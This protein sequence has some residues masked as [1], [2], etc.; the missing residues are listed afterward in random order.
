M[1]RKRH[2]E[3]AYER[4]IGWRLASRLD[5]SLRWRNNPARHIQPRQMTL[6]TVST[7]SSLIN[8]FECA[9]LLVKSLTNRLIAVVS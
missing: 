7:W 8:T 2:S 9:E 6:Q 5:R 4:T 1:A 3:S